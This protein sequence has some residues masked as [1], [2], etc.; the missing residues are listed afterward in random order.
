MGDYQRWK[1]PKQIKKKMHVLSSELR[2]RSTETENLLWE[3]L[4]NRQLL[5]RKFRRQTPIG[6]YVVDFYCAQEKLVIEIDGGIH[7]TQ[8]EQDQLRQETL[9]ALGLRVIRLTVDQVENQ[10]TESLCIIQNSFGS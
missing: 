4:R 2:Q 5:G 9:E 1:Q 6:A 3:K 10:L 8:Q 7:E